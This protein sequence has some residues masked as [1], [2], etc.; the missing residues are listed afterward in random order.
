MANSVHK[1]AIHREFDYSIH[2]NNIVSIPLSGAFRPV[3][4]GF[5]PFPSWVIR[6]YLHPSYPEKL[7]MYIGDWWINPVFFMQF[8]PIQIQH[9]YLYSTRIR[10]IIY[11]FGISVT[12]N[13][14][15]GIPSGI[16]M[17]PLYM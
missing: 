4:D 13:E 14:N 17:F 11:G 2:T 9:L 1:L 12:P 7:S 5:A 10:F 16:Q 6:N 3:F 8:Y 15:S